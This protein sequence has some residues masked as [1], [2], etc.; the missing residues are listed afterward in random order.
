MNIQCLEDYIKPNHKVDPAEPENPNVSKIDDKQSP[1]IEERLNTSRKI[2][3][4]FSSRGSRLM[5]GYA[6]HLINLKEKTPKVP[7]IIDGKN[8]RSSLAP[9]FN[10]RK[11]RKSYVSPNPL[12]LKER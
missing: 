10:N 6:A 3:K 8:I 1:S 4:Q 2:P 5:S 11:G 12:S 7:S 9:L